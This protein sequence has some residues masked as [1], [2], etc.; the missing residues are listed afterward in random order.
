[1]VRPKK[2]NSVESTTRKRNMLCVCVCVFAQATWRPTP[3]HDLVS[4]HTSV[5]T[6]A[7]ALIPYTMHLIRLMGRY[8]AL[9]LLNAS[10]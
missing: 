1:M 3:F 7:I 6:I 8:R 5:H 10:R 2:V 4:V 9:C